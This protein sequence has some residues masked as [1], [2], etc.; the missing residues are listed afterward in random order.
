MMFALVLQIL[1]LV[2]LPVGGFVAAGVG[3]GVVGASLSLVFVGLALE[4][5]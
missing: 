3:G 5:S 4:R 2:G 1:G